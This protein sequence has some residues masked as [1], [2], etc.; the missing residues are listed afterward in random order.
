[1]EIV[2]AD[3]GFLERFGI[4]PTRLNL[5]EN[6][7][8]CLEDIIREGNLYRFN[9]VRFIKYNSQKEN[10]TVLALGNHTLVAAS[11]YGF[12]PQ[13]EVYSVGDGFASKAL[14]DTQVAAQSKTA[15]AGVRS[16]DDLFK[17]GSPERYIESIRARPG[18]RA[19]PAE[20]TH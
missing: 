14:F 17:Y 20:T 4:G 18:V 2:T 8:N 19:L 6:I 10:K 9:P 15:Q 7:L 11:F 5:D 12:S 13:G 1:M 3:R 16:F